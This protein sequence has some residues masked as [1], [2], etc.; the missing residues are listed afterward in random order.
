MFGRRGLARIEHSFIPEAYI[1][2]NE[3]E[4]TKAKCF[5]A[6]EI[7]VK[8]TSGLMMCFVVSVLPA[9]D[10]PLITK[11]RAWGR[12]QGKLGRNTMTL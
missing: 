3:H 6:A 9:P 2:Q 5:A 10:S 7:T 12:A 11:D 4:E 1:F 8:N